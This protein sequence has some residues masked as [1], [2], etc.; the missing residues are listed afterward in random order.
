MT[1]FTDPL[2]PSDSNK[3]SAITYEAPLRV[4]CIDDDMQFCSYMHFMAQ[5]FNL[6]FRSIFSFKE[7][8]ELIEKQPFDVYL[9]DMSL[10]DGSGFDLAALV[11]S[12][13]GKEVYI[14]VISGVFNDA[15]TFRTLKEQL[16]INYVLDKPVKSQVV[17]SLFSLLCQKKEQVKQEEPAG[18]KVSFQ[19]IKDRYDATIFEK[20]SQVESLIK[21]VQASPQQ[22]NLELLK[23]VIHK[24]AGS[25]G[26]YGY[27]QVALL[28]RNLE[29]ALIALL[30]EIQQD[31][32]LTSQLPDLKGFFKELKL[33]FQPAVNKR[34]E[35]LF[36]KLPLVAGRLPLLVINED[37]QF[38]DLIE[39]YK[40][41]YGLEVLCLDNP[42]Q[43]LEKLAS[44][45]FHPRMIVAKERYSNSS[46]TGFDLIDSV[47]KKQGAASVFGL[48]IERDGLDMR[49]EAL[50]KGVTYFFAMP[51]AAET[52]LQH[53][54]TILHAEYLPSGK[55]LVV[56]DDP[57]ICRFVSLALNEEGMEV[58]TLSDGI[59]LFEEL[60]SYM[61]HC[62]LL[63][64]NLPVI[65]GLEILRT[66]T[67]DLRYQN[68]SIVVITV[69]QDI[70]MKETA[71]NANVDD[72]FYKPLNKAL[73]QMRVRQL[74][75]RHAMLA[76]MPARDELTGLANGQA[77]YAFLYRTMTHLETSR[78]S[79]LVLFEIDKFQDVKT[80]IGQHAANKL[81]IS[82]GNSLLRR[83]QKF[84][85]RAYL[86]ESMF[87]I[88]ATTSQLDDLEAALTGI[89]QAALQEA[90][91]QLSFPKLF[92]STGLT[93]LK[94]HRY[95][96]NAAMEAAKEALFRAQQRTKNS[97]VSIEGAHPQEEKPRQFELVLIDSDED[98]LKMLQAAFSSYDIKVTTYAS[99]EQAMQQLVGRKSKELPDLIIAER[100]LGDL[101]S[102]EIL[103]A[104]AERHLTRPPFIFL[105][106]FAA[107][108]DILEGLKQGAVDYIAKPFNLTILLQKV[109][110][111]LT[112]N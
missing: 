6:I 87:A 107:D 32:F 4:L 23:G 103:K 30:A 108:E 52:F 74:V 100:Q 59:H 89:M 110:A 104:L 34:I 31:G 91:P 99:G 79:Y 33:G 40:E 17:Q 93:A 109:F 41:K 97:L 70:S 85:F 86:G 67:A 26:S 64:I 102:L 80:L 88:V 66:L 58:R 25:S 8:K 49:I 24:I 5:P 60:N 75:K 36:Q 76:R 19:A 90:I 63:D 2:S 106:T 72:I 20:L 27:P 56:D 77:L 57:D 16:N 13:Y 1:N 84:L 21:E 71:Y 68:L 28:C 3:E 94:D 54:Q 105:S 53:I 55:V 47:Q 61:P 81:L 101:N 111:L 48:F 18:D 78:N 35:P 37:R 98:L 95:D 38:L 22:E 9:I 12:L 112:K 96:I 43:A 7:A 83:E 62:L 50:Q 46:I 14:V 73:L 10:P 45:D 42:N 69:R 65:N 51:V 92:L 82:I 15:A 39:R 29:S 11:R 44:E